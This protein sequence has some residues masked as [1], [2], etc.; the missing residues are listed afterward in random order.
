MKKRILT[1]LLVLVFLL[2]LSAFVSAESQLWYITDDAGI[3]TSDENT[4]LEA[5]AQSVSETYG[6]GVYIVTIDDYS[7]YYDDPYETAWQIYHEYTLGEGDD[8]DGVIL[9]LSMDNRKFATFFYGPQAEYAFNA[10]G[11]ELLEGYFLDDFRADDWANG[12]RHFLS[13]C[14]YFLS[15]AASGD[16]VRQGDYSSGGDSSQDS[17]VSPLRFIS[18]RIIGWIVFSSMFFSL[19][20]CVLLKGKMRSVRK[21][22]AAN[23]Y[24]SGELN[25]TASRDQ[26]THT[27]ET[28]TRIEHESSGGSHAESGGGGSGRSGSF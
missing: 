10:Y 21:A 20:V 11:Q 18:W 16:P 28:R 8:R 17:S 24:V 1:V 15:Q 5:Y 6:V 12:C 3:L 27:T 9:L 7:D 23:A 4:E 19:I 22:S 14:E 2:G 26:Y 25:L 13:G